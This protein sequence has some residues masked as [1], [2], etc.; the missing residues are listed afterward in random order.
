MGKKKTI[1]ETD[2]ARRERQIM[3]AV[4]QLGEASVGEVREQIADAPSYSA[5]R[6]MIRSLEAKGLLT[7]RQEGKRYVYKAK[8]SRETASK[9]AMRRLLN[10]F[11]AGSAHDA[12][13]SILDVTAKDL[14]A[15]ELKRIEQLIKQARTEGR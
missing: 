8:Q 1:G 14:A 4:H 7:H 9:S 15:D 13:A 2:L 5:V 11:F 6:T 3:D 12:V 10:V